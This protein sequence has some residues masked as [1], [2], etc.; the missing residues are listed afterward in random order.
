M[1]LGELVLILGSCYSYGS[2]YE[3]PY[4]IFLRYPSRD[5]DLILILTLTLNYSR[6]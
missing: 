6:V 5:P 4:W 3:Y 2:V 1:R